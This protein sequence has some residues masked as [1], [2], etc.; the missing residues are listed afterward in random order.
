MAPF[1]M[2]TWDDGPDILHKIKVG[3][4]CVAVNVCKKNS[5]AV[6]NSGGSVRHGKKL[7]VCEMKTNTAPLPTAHCLQDLT[8]PALGWKVDLLA[9]VLSLCN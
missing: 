2:P 1:Q 5:Y 7:N 9:N 4:S 8:A 3:L 6:R